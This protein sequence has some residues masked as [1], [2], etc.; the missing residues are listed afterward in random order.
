ME[1]LGA[2]VLSDFA[3]QHKLVRIVDIINFEGPLLTLYENPVNGHLFLYDWIDYDK[4]HNRWLMY[5]CK[6]IKIWEF[7]H[8][9]ISHFD[10]FNA[11]NEEVYVLDINNK[12]LQIENVVRMNRKAL[13]DIYFPEKEAYFE[14]SDCIQYD[15][16]IE[17]VKIALQ[18]KENELAEIYNYETIKSEHYDVWQKYFKPKLFDYNLSNKLFSYN[19]TEIEVKSISY[20]QVTQ[21]RK[22]ENKI[23]QNITKYLNH[24]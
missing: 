17:F 22:D 3:L 1:I 13:P 21:N 6:P 15:K 7:I 5:H 2:K 11:E 12:S 8:Q 10:L 14:N 18:N 24:V 19:Y 9:K 4:K 20:I 23:N 16:L